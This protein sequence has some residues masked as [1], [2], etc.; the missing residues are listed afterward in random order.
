MYPYVLSIVGTLYLLITM[1]SP[2]TLRV[3]LR[4]IITLIGLLVLA[5]LP[6]VT[7]LTLVHR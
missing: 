5:R 1:I 4:S 3:I 7:T 2:I 6:C